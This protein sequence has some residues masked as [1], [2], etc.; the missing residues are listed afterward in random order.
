MYDIGRL[1]M[2]VAGRDAGRY[3]LV[4]DAKDGK[5]LVDGQTRRRLVNEHHLEPLDKSVKLAKGASHAD[6]VK[7]LGT[8][9]IAVKEPK[10]RP[11]KAKTEKKADKSEKPTKKASAKKTKKASAKKAKQ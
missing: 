9:G 6:V 2:K 5:L 3:C 8:L 11:K 7:A 1:C 10:E 4:V